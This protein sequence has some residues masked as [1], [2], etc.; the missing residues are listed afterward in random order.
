MST[1]VGERF[2]V[3]DLDADDV[4]AFMRDLDLEA[5]R[6][7]AWKLR[8]AAHW[9]DLHPATTDT[10][11]AAPDGSVLGPDETLGGDGTP[12]VAA[13]TPEEL[14]VVLRVSPSSA[15]ALVADAL[16][17]RHRFPMLWT[18]V[19]RCEVPAWLA[20]RVAQQTRA[21][22]QA[23]AAYVDDTLAARTT[24]WGTGVLDR[25]V[26]HAIANFDTA[27]QAE[28]EDRGQGSW[29][30]KL[31]H[32]GPT[33]FAGTSELWARGDTVALQRLYDQ[34][35]AHAHQAL[36]DGDPDPLG[37]RKAKALGDLG[38]A[39][40]QPG[41]ARLYLHIDAADLDPEASAIGTVEKLGPATTTKIRQWVG[42]SR[43]TIVPVLDLDR[44]DPVD[45]HDP[46]H[47]MR[48]HVILRD[49]HCVFPGCTRDARSCDLDHI[50]PYL[51]P[52][53]GGPPG[54]T[55]PT[56][57]APLC[58]RHH[59]AKTTGLWRY[60]RTPD[61]RCLWRGPYGVTFLASP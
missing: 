6:I 37:P 47:R 21:L 7:E 55:R 42:H 58:R 8:A 41:K 25:V 31:T 19:M 36:L 35:C 32:P 12:S 60:T 28:K 43:V 20:R 59:R 2:E 27:A 33:E 30:V 61:G 13:F 17:L 51:D 15:A 10:G 3:E 57:L 38:V 44:D 39:D 5:R 14:G 23:G 40:Q 22:P 48:E 18:Q 16:D 46:P 34:I 29:D 53:D 9:A 26:A 56:N 11:A 52:G 24:P 45:H 54:Q 1:T 50:E 49:H 4:L